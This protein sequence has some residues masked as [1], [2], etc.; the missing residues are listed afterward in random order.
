MVTFGAGRKVRSPFPVC[1]YVSVCTCNTEVIG[2][3]EDSRTSNFA[4]KS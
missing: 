1:T 3:T 4:S 2:D